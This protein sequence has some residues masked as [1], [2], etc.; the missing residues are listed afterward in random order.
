[1][2]LAL[3]TATRQISMALYDGQQITAEF[4]W[5]T[6]SRHTVE[7]APACENMMQRAGITPTELSA[8]AVALGPGSYT[9]LRIGM[10]IAKGLALAADPPLPLIGIPTLDIVA[11]AQP[12]LADRLC[13]VAQAGRGRISAG[14][15]TW[16][17]NNWQSTDQP[18]IIDWETL[19]KS[20]DMHTQFGGEIDPA[21]LADHPHVILAQ[22]AHALRR[23]GFLAEL[24]YRR[25]AGGEVDGAATLAPIYLK[26]P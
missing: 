19:L 18:T 24:A 9:G 14:F 23:A 4:T 15:Y 25:F 13:V 2:L 20:L 11:A 12:H 6:A 3:D 22:P 10:G 21:L 5:R 17:A 7:L 16:E 1:M 8:I 26:E